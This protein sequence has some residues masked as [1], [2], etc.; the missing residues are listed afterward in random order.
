MFIFYF[1]APDFSLLKFSI[2]ANPVAAKAKLMG[3]ND[4]IPTRQSE[5]KQAPIFLM[6][7]PTGL[8]ARNVLTFVTVS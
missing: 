1:Y 3:E 4:A 2:S 7:P 6:Q 5:N 8:M